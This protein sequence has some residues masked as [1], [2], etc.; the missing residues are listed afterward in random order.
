MAIIVFTEPIEPIRFISTFF[1]SFN[2]AKS[3]REQ[4]IQP[5]AGRPAEEPQPVKRNVNRGGFH[6]SGLSVCTCFQSKEHDGFKP[7]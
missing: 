3:F 6:R 2:S 1:G 4:N 5:Y 7:S